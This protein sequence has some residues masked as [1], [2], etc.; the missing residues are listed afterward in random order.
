LIFL[1]AEVSEQ[2]IAVGL[3]RTRVSGLSTLRK[4]QRKE[5]RKLIIEIAEP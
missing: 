3:K 4:N 5:E 2:R 1:K